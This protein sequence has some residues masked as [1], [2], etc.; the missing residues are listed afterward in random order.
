MKPNMKPKFLV[1]IALLAFVAVSMITL[2][3][4]EL[5]NKSAVPESE[6]NSTVSTLEDRIVVYYFHGN[7][8]CVTCRTIESYTR[9]VVETAF[10]DYLNNGSMEFQVINVETPSTT[11]FIQDYQLYAPSVV[12]VQLDDNAQVGWRNLDSVW[13]LVGDRGTFLSY[14]EDEITAM[15]QGG[16]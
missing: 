5:E 12:L 7:A 3:A 15:L 14:I 11:H 1:T 6:V 9:E 8:R 10:A 16:L 2:I 13:Q 4:K